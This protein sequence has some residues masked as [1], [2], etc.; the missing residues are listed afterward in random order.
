M[1]KCPNCWTKYPDHK[2]T[3]D[4]C[5]VCRGETVTLVPANKPDS[6]DR[7]HNERTQAQKEQAAR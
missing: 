2:K 7:H 4:V 5:W 3:C 6:R 1:K